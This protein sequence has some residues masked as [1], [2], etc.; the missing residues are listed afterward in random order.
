MS[1]GLV[2]IVGGV[3]L[4][5]A[6]GWWVPRQMEAVRTRAAARGRSERF[7]RAIASWPYRTARTAV[8]IAGAVAV[9]T[10]VLVAFGM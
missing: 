4:M 1:D 8:V 7:D 10:G 3:Y 2:L 6:A 5:A 9:I